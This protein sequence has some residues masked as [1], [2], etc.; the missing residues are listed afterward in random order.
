MGASSSSKAAEVSNRRFIRTWGEWLQV[1][2]T[3]SIHGPKEAGSSA[4]TCQRCSSS[5][6]SSTRDS[7]KRLHRT[8]SCCSSRECASPSFASQ[9][10]I[11]TTIA[12]CL[13]TSCSSTS[14]ERQWTPSSASTTV[15]CSSATAIAPIK[16]PS[17]TSVA[18]FQ[19]SPST[20]STLFQCAS[21]PSFTIFRC[22]S[23]ASSSFLKRSSTTA[24]ANFWWTSRSS[25]STSKSGFRLPIW[26]ACLTTTTYW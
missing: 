24:Y 21:S 14:F 19:C 15:E 5:A 20:S 13:F 22:T 11:W 3:S 23:S 18:L 10:T 17:S 9:D 8:C 1:W 2:S 6:T 26:S 4:D 25:S 12:A 16:C 7:A